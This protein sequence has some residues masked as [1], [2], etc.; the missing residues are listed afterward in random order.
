MTTVGPWAVRAAVTSCSSRASGPRRAAPQEGRRRRGRAAEAFG[1]I[2]GRHLV[3][4]EALV[5]ALAQGGGQGLVGH[6]APPSTRRPAGL[7]GGRGRPTAPPHPS[8]AVPRRR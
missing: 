8:P 3:P 2:Q 7:L 5:V 6:G 1:K 4:E